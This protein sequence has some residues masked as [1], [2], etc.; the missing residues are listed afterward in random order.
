[1]ESRSTA[2]L[3]A[4]LSGCG[5][6]VQDGYL[7]PVQIRGLGRCAA[8]RRE[9]GDFG[10][11]RIGSG[12]LR[13]RRA[14]VRGDNTCWLVPATPPAPCAPPPTPLFPEEEALVA[15]LERLRLDLNRHGYLGLFDLELHHAWYPPGAGYARHVDQ[16]DGRGQRVVSLVLYL[17]DAWPADAGGELRLFDGPE[18]RDIAPVGRA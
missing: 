16:L 1:V 10:E 8:V 2:D 12:R 7:T 4:G 13:Q 11:A 3:N 14:D 18:F 17:N 15:D 5:L 9:R 6:A